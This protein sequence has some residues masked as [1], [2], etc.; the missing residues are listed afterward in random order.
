VLIFVYISERRVHNAVQFK[1]VNGLVSETVIRRFSGFHF[2]EKYS[3]ILESYDIDLAEARPVILFK[4]FKF[5]EREVIF[6]EI[7]SG[8]AELFFIHIFAA[9]QRGVDQS[10]VSN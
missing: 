3:I 5:I 1:P 6:G 7:F 10:G 9:R 2:K 8:C 4:N